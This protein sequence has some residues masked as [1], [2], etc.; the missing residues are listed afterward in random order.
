MPHSLQQPLAGPIV[1]LGDPPRTIDTFLSRG[2]SGVERRDAHA[3]SRS[4][5]RSAHRRRT[6]R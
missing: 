1:L 2:V 5:Y 6:E 3:G 4:Y